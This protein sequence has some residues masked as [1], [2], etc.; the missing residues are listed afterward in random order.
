MSSPKFLWTGILVCNPNLSVSSTAY[1]CDGSGYS[2]SD[3]QITPTLIV[4]VHYAIAACFCSC[5][6]QPAHWWWSSCSHAYWIWHCSSVCND[7]SILQQTPVC[8]HQL[9]SSV[10]TSRYVHHAPLA[11]LCSDVGWYWVVIRC[12]N[13]QL[14]SQIL[15]LVL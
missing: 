10:H 14:T 9:G 5:W 15:P 8:R 6:E 2:A 13:L 3:N 7:R 4:S 1:D 11:W 12:Q